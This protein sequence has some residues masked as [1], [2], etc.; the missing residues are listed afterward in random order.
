MR[1]LVHALTALAAALYTWESAA[2]C[3]PTPA[4]CQSCEHLRE[5]SGGTLADGYYDISPDG[6]TAIEAYCVNQSGRSWT[7]IDPSHDID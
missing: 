4:A 5:N 1:I 7:V 6:V 3:P 2:Q